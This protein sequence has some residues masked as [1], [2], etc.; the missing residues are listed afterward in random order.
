M[1]SCK[2]ALYQ[3]MTDLFPNIITGL[4]LVFTKYCVLS[5][6]SHRSI[7]CLSLSASE[8]NWSSHHSYTVS[9]YFSQPCLTVV[10]NNNFTNHQNGKSNSLGNCIQAEFCALEWVLCNLYS[11]RCYKNTQ[12]FD[13][14]D[15]DFKD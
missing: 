7:T 8:N 4:H 11:S 5:A 9:P 3:I 15:D 14:T 10:L 2:H 12:S 13:D 1:C 6:V